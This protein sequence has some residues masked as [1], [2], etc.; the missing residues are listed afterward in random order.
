MNENV[1]RMYDEDVKNAKGDVAKIDL[2]LRSKWLYR[3]QGTN[4]NT[5]NNRAF[6]IHA[7]VVTRFI[8]KHTSAT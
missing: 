7:A 1:T 5:I 2:I 4:E 8:L 3:H 6:D